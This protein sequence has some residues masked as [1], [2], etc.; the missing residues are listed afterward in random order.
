MPRKDKIVRY[1][2]A[3]LQRM[4]SLTNWD[5]VLAMTD[6]E[7]LAAIAS[8]PDAGELDESRLEEA[9]W[10]T[11]VRF[12]LPVWRWLKAQG[13]DVHATVGAVLKAAMAQS[14]EG[15]A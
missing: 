2:T 11:I 15:D 6:D 5:A 14:H 3:E 9:C 4:P 1:T 7:T 12:E 13:S 10:Q 8:D